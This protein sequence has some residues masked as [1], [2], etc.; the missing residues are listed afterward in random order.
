[1]QAL[2]RLPKLRYL[3]LDPI[4]RWS[5]PGFTSLMY[6]F[7]DLPP[8]TDRPRVTGRSLAAF[9][10]AAALEGLSL[11]DAVV[12][13]DDLV[14]LA[15]MPKLAR[16]S[17]PCVI[18]AT[19]VGHLQACRRLSGL[20][21]GYREV[22]ADEIKRLAGWKGLRSLTITHAELSATALAALAA[23]PA[24][25]SLEL[26]ACGITDDRL[27][28]L[29][30]P[31]TVTTLSLRQNPLAGPGL[32]AIDSPSLKTLGLEH[33]DLADDSL[34]VL[35]AFTGLEKLFLSYCK[36][37]TDQGIRSGALQSMTQLRELRLRGL[38]Q[39]T[40][41]AVA[42]LGKFGHLK[43]ISVRGAGVSWDGVAQMKRAMPETFVFK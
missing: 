9:A 14:A 38:Q 29:R 37:I 17:L 42:D 34:S 2:A 28:Q 30:L 3:T 32:A 1:M 21:L 35:P 33:T 41:A 5:R 18:D 4:E 15:R 13:S 10:D 40:D 19:A 25:I 20:T 8:V 7:S 43:T 22:T 6:C 12:E 11:L 26:V 39:V 31:A 36:G 16:V 27:A 23:L 24:I